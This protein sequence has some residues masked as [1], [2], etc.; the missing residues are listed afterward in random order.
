[1]DPAQPDPPASLRGWVTRGVARVLRIPLLSKLVVLDV[2]INLLALA[3]M[4]ATPLEYAERVTILSLGLTLVLN[5]GLVYYALRPLQVLEETARRVS[6]GDYAARARMPWLADRNLVRIG[7]TLNTLIVNVTA[8]RGRVRELAGEV[9]AAG[10]RERAQIA[11]DLHDGTA[12]SL[13][14]LDMVLSSVLADPSSEPLR[15]QLEAVRDIASTSLAELR[16]LSH[17]IHPR[18]LDDLGLV[19]A[20]ENLARRAAARGGPTVSVEAR[21]V[22][23]PA[24]VA[25]VLYRVGFEAVHNAVRHAQATAVKVQLEVS[26]TRAVLRVTDD[27]RGFARARVPGPRHGIGL[28]VMEERVALVD[29]RLDIRSAPGSGTEVRAEVPLDPA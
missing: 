5:T 6:Q 20:L 25:S 27:G 7:E 17:E 18:V 10:E 1:M 3:V 29:G 4:R 2:G 12:Q 26:S 23:L 15:D 21:P 13:S 28:F 24:T 16:T 9:V 14:A 8:E 22:E 19:P 11:R